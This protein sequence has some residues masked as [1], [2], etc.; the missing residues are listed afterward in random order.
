MS[1]SLGDWLIGA[2]LEAQAFVCIGALILYSE[3]LT[4][5]A[6]VAS[7]ALMIAGLE[8]L[9]PRRE[10]AEPDHNEAETDD[11]AQC[12]E[13]GA[14][15]REAGDLVGDYRRESHGED[16][17]SDNDE[18]GSGDSSA[19]LHVQRRENRR[20]LRLVPWSPRGGL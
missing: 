16:E 3:W 2:G 10:P 18:G 6:S 13:A 9:H 12:R 4:V 19:A 11:H 5:G 14:K 17:C 15:G 8:L 7:F 20:G 1:A